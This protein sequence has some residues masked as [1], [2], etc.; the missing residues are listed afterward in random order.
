MKQDG[1]PNRRAWLRSLGLAGGAAGVFALSGKTMGAGQSVNEK[2]PGIFNVADY[3]AKGDGVADDTDA[4][5]NAINAAGNFS[6]GNVS[7]GGVVLLPTGVYMVSR[8]L[9]ITQAVKVF[10]HG[11]ATIDGATHIVP[12]SLGFDVLKIVGVNWGVVLEG[13]H[14]KGYNYAGTGGHF[15][16]IE[17]CQHVHIHGVHLINCWNGALVDSSGD[18]YFYDLNV[19][20]ADIPGDGR[21]GIKCT[22]ASKGNANATQVLNCTVSQWGTHVRTMDGFVLANGYNSLAAIN[23]G[24]LNCNRGFWSTKDGGVA[25]NFFVISGVGCSDHSNRA[26]ALDDGGFTQ[27]SGMCITSSYVDNI[28]VGV[29]ITGPVAFSHCVVSTSSNAGYR[30]TSVRTPSVSIT[31]GSVHDTS[32]NAIEIS[33]NASVLVTGVGISS[34]ES[35]RDADGVRVSGSGNI[36]LTGLSITRVKHFG[37]H[38]AAD[39]AGTLNFSGLNQ[40]DA[41]RG[42]YDE[43]SSGIIVGNGS[44]HG[45]S[46]LDVDL[47]RNRNGQTCVQTHSSVPWPAY[48]TPAVPATGTSVHNTSGTHCMVYILGG[49]VHQVAVDDVDVG[50]Q[51]SIYLPVARSITI[52][53]SGT[54][55]WVWQRVT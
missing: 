43:G 13:F 50:P 41:Q 55:S 23:C 49:R 48:P 33:G 30:I 32:G 18:V 20:G 2:D 34:I 39:F 52:K 54:L 22:A 38:V 31:G 3:G 36:T 12:S 4:I 14:I 19:S 9:L 1:K 35:G 6:K 44:F 47:S 17:G 27:V 28:T 24:A 46:V 8:T 5:Q 40:Q 51:T 37:I 53:Y 29:N 26:V 25:P 10:G 15:L 11:Q 45:N 42:L 7:K 21:F 16:R